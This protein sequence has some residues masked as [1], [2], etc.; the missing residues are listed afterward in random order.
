[1]A[2]RP[3]FRATPERRRPSGS[4]C[5]GAAVWR[6]AQAAS[7]LNRLGRPNTPTPRRPPWVHGCVGHG[8]FGW[9]ATGAGE[10]RCL[11]SRVR[12]GQR[13]RCGGSWRQRA[14]VPIRA[15]RMATVCCRSTARFRRGRVSG[16]LRRSASVFRAGWAASGRRG[17]EP[18]YVVSR[19][20]VALTVLIYEIMDRC[21]GHGGHVGRET[22]SGTAATA[23][24]VTTA[25]TAA[26]A[27]PTPQPLQHRHRDTATP[28]TQSVPPRTQRSTQI[29]LRILPSCI[30]YT[31]RPR[32]PSWRQYGATSQH[33]PWQRDR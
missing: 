14:R 23:D 2:R 7:L 20:S 6:V 12:S 26:T 8:V 5:L 18:P 17:D 22:Q 19:Q 32:H 33:T 21:G 4:S 29:Q 30:S 3:C 10:Q 9:V 25:G 27:T 28:H 31:I 1:M 24:T 13:G 16:S 15:W 11:P